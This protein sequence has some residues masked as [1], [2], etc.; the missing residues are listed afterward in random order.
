MTCS[1]RSRACS[2]SANSSSVGGSGDL[3][4]VLGDEIGD[5]HAELFE[6][7]L[8][9]LLDAQCRL[10]FGDLVAMQRIGER[11][12]PRRELGDLLA[13]LGQGRGPDLTFGGDLVADP[14]CDA[15][16]GAQPCRDQP[17]G[18][19]N[20]GRHRCGVHPRLTCALG[21]DPGLAFCGRGAS[22]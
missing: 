12:D 15:H 4:T 13:R 17:S 22:Q 6:H 9:E 20:R 7:L 18:L 3:G 5:G 21:T 8:L 16:R 11:V 2:Y 1:P 19:G 10:R 14:G